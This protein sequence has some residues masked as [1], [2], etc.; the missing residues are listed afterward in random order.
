MKNRFQL[1]SFFGI[2]NFFKKGR[3]LIKSQMHHKFCSDSKLIVN[4]MKINHEQSFRLNI[5]NIETM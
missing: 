3:N 4:K 1:I 5:I 2:E